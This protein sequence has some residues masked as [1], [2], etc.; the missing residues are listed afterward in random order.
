MSVDISRLRAT[1]IGDLVSIAHEIGIDNAANLK[2]Q[3]VIFEIVRHRGLDSQAA[4]GSGVLEILPDGFGFM[5]SQECNFAPGPDDIYVSPSQIRRFNLRTGDL[6]GGQVRAPKDGERYFALIKIE[7]VNGEHPEGMRAKPIF[8]SLTPIRPA[9]QMQFTNGVD[10]LTARLID[11]YLPIGFGQRVAVFCSTQTDRITLFSELIHGIRSNH[12]STKVL[13]L[14]L[15]ERPEEVTEIQRTVQAEV[16]YSTF[17]E[18]VDRHVQVTDMT[19]ERAK[20]MAEKGEHV[21]LFIDS[22]SRLARAAHAA[23]PAGGKLMNSLVDIAALQCVRRVFG[24]A[25]CL[26]EGGSLT[27]F[28]TMMTGEGFDGVVAEDL[29]A[30]ANG[31]LRLDANTEGGATHAALNLRGSRTSATANFLSAD[32]HGALIERRTALAGDPGKDLEAAIAA[33]K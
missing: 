10:N 27:I 8:D 26:E 30:A 11:N 16:M 33:I 25:R 31:I 2:R 19:I 7:S 5:R 6:I 21:V 9:T 32:D 15:D 24:A 12:P 17:D 23:T 18:P 22:L 28:G 4:S 13:L 1:S 14:L 29:I 20:R 3:E